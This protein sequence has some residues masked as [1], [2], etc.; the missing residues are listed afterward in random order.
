MRC[1][2]SQQRKEQLENFS[3]YLFLEIGKHVEIPVSDR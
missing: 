1:S 2:L 3:V